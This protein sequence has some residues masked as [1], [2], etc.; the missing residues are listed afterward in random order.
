VAD[1]RKN[2]RRMRWSRNFQKWLTVICSLWFAQSLAQWAGWF[3]DGSV[4]ARD[5][6]MSAALLG[7]P[8]SSLIQERSTAWGIVLLVVTAGLLVTSVSLR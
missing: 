8:A 3:G 2:E 4:P 5:V 1:V 7:V 6:L